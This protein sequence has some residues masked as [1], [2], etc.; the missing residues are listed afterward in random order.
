MRIS[1]LS[2]AIVVATT[3]VN[4]AAAK[5]DFS[6]LLAG[7]SYGQST[8][9]S[10]SVP[11]YVDRHVDELLPAPS[12]FVMPNDQEVLAPQAL[13]SGPV[14]SDPP[15]AD[16]VDLDAA[17]AMQQLETAGRGVAV[18]AVGFGHS[19]L[20][21]GCGGGC[22]SGGCDGLGSG[23]CESC[24]P[25]VPH[26]PVNLPS[27]TF[28]QYFRSNKCHTNVWDGYQ[29]ACGCAHKH[30]TGQCDC[31]EKSSK[32]CCLGS[33]FGSCGEILP[34][35]PRVVRRACDCDGGGCDDVGCD[36]CTR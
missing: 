32:K 27:S 10:N 18:N 6:D 34:A 24:G 5:D 19:R 26:N 33:A 2:I 3:I 4:A 28:L 25:C 17:F 29:Q 7:L 36:R 14:V 12:G 35:M 8:P 11:G 30:V 31:M 22:D 15:H 23:G 16:F 20:H 21:D 9:I 13:L 1:A